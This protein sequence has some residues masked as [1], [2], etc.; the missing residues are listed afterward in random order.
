MRNR[1][2]I[3]LIITAAIFSGVKTFA[4]AD[5]SMATHWYNRANYNPASIARP[6]Y[7]YFFSNVRQQWLG[8]NGSPAVFNIQLS[9]YI[10][11]MRSAFGISLVG[12]KIGVTRAYNPMLTYAYRI[13]NDP[14]WSFSMGL[15][16]GVFTR[17]IDGSLYEP[18]IVT[19][20]PSVMIKMPALLPMPASDWNINPLILFSA[21]PLPIF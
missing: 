13:A 14:E 17:F 1:L 9:Q 3:I 20:P 8:I 7:L 21:S 4:Q 15:A 12:D 5:I 2:T 11:P 6:E 19:D 18:V 16:A 10:H